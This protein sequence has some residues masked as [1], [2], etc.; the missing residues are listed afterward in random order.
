MAENLYK[1]I[2]KTASEKNNN[3]TDKA[4]GYSE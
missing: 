1:K 3:T 2:A 4:S